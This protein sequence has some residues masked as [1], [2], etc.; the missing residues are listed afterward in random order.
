M[1]VH[2]IESGITVCDKEPVIAKETVAT[3]LVDGQNLLGPVVGTFAME[4][5]IKKAHEVGVGW[6][7]ANSESKILS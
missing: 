2:D 6:V 5:A 3:A 4:L 7:V 1:Y